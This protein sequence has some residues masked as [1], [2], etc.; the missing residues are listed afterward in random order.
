MSDAIQILE[1]ALAGEE[2]DREIERLTQELFVAKAIVE[3]LGNEREKI[4]SKIEILEDNLDRARSEH[5]EQLRAIIQMLEPLA[6]HEDKGTLYLSH[7]G[8]AAMVYMIQ[9]V[10]YAN[11]EKLD[12]ILKPYANDF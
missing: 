12:P 8:K 10:I 5:L 6:T 11:I 2:R 9:R 7:F 4:N 1:A 3:D